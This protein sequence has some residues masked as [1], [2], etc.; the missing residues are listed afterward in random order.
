M[1]ILKAFILKNLTPNTKYTITLEV[2]GANSTKET[3]ELSFTTLQDYPES[4]RDIFLDPNL[5]ENYKDARNSFRLIVNQPG[6]LGYWKNNAN[7]YELQLY[8]NSELIK[9]KIIN[10]VKKLSMTDFNI[11]KEF[12][13]TCKTGDNIQIGVRTWVKTDTGTVL[14]DA[15]TAKVSKPVCL[16][17]KPVKSFLNLKKD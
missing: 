16:L 9:K 11:A 3:K 10:K 7:G 13:Y 4:I 15:D 8:V 6:S 17:N 5:T 1:P 12:G 14:Y 2:L